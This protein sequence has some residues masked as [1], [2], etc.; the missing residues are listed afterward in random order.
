MRA[1]MSL[2][3]LITL[4]MVIAFTVPVVLL[5]F[6]MSQAG[7]ESTALVQAE[8]DAKTL[9][10]SINEAYAE[11]P[12]AKRTVFLNLPVSTKKIMVANNEVTIVVDTSAGEYHAVAPFFAKAITTDESYGPVES[13]K[14][15][16]LGA[17]I[18]EVNKDNLVMVHG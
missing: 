9:S 15:R 5:L 6:S 8:A 18:V 1:Q 14:L 2:E 12:G 16:G 7:L 13:L 17:L 4:G 11:G 10:D 3:L